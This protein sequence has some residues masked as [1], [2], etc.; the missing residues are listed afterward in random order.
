MLTQHHDHDYGT[1]TNTTRVARDEEAQNVCTRRTRSSLLK[2][3][4]LRRRLRQERASLSP[5][6]AADYTDYARAHHHDDHDHGQGDL[7]HD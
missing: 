3:D 7:E 1:D 4:R 2:K 5:S 6:A